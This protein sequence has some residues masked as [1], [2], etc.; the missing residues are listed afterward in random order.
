MVLTKK[1]NGTVIVLVRGTRLAL[2]EKIAGEIEIQKIQEPR[3]DWRAGGKGELRESRKAWESQEL[4]E[5][6]KEREGQAPRESRKA[7][8]SQEL[9]ESRKARESQEP[10][11]SRKEREGQELRESRKAW[12]GQAPREIRGL[13]RKQRF[14]ETRSDP[15]SQE[16]QNSRRPEEKAENSE[17]PG[18]HNSSSSCDSLSFT[19]GLAGNPNCGKT[20]LFNALTGER[21]KT[22]NWP[23]VT[24]ERV[25]GKTVWRGQTVHIVDLPGI[26]SLDSYTMEERITRSCLEGTELSLIVN[27]ADASSLERNLYLTL[28]LLACGKP[29]VLALNMMDIAKK[30]GLWIDTARLS[31]MLGNIPVIPVSAR[32]RE[33]LDCLMESVF[34]IVSQGFQ[35]ERYSSHRKEG[36]MVSAERLSVPPADPEIDRK[37]GYNYIEQILIECVQTPENRHFR[38]VSG[39]NGCCWNRADDI[40]THPVFGIPAF[41]L[42]ISVVFF[43]T[44]TVGDFLKGYLETGLYSLSLTARMLLTGFH[45]S[46]WLTS[47]LVD[48]ILAGAGGVLTFLPNLV[49]LFLALA[50]L[51]DS[52]YMSRAAYVM[53]EAMGRAGLSGK[54]FLPMLLGFGCSVPAVMAARTLETMQD[55]RRTI[56]MIPF[57]SCSARLPIYVLFSGMFFPEHAMAV[58]LL[59]YIAGAAA[60]ILTSWAV[61]A[62]SREKDGVPEHGSS[63]LLI[64]LPD[65]HLPDPRTVFLSVWERV[66]DYLTKAGTTICSAALLLWVVLHTGPQGFSDVLSES[67]A[68]LLGKALVPVLRP[69]GLGSWQTAVALLSGLSAKEVVVSSFFVLYG[70][71]GAGSAE[72]MSRL[73]GFL[74]E[75]G[76]TAANAGAL[77]VFCLLYPPCM[78]ALSVIQKETRSFLW[79]TGMVVLQLGLAWGAAAAVFQAGSL[80][81]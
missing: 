34:S 47:L 21:L 1:K 20:T 25:E 2:G 49:M 55:K 59:L 30:R 53:N 45:V 19:I 18:V 52:G 36:R 15:Q 65:Y 77:M 78:A 81:G 37:K 67:Y 23:G 51:E 6:R 79:T 17:S 5:S 74:R 7:W 38:P 69:A 71:E 22:A 33:G 29:V 44:F 70:I 43:L 13:E 64:E 73:A 10:R 50:V 75:T 12:E 11:G 80:L 61:R 48:G 76:F 63:L 35:L 16:G 39:M 4:R 14:C 24:V 46:D 56:W 26:Y 3:G 8:E 41:F 28:Q 54:A 72:G 57:M 62:L 40:M 31:Q 66:K 27:V 68:A 58:T 32:K 60:A 42:I 9:R